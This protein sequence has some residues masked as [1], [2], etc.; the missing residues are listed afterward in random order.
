MYAN[1]QIQLFFVE[2]ISHSMFIGT[3]YFIE[4]Y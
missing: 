3:Q 2:L 1:A 4:Q